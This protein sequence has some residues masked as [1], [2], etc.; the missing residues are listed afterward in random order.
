MYIKKRDR[1]VIEEVNNICLRNHLPNDFNNWLDLYPFKNKMYMFFKIIKQ[2]NKSKFLGSCQNC[3]SIEIKLDSVKTGKYIKCPCCKKQVRLKNEKFLKNFYDRDYVYYITPINKDN[4]ILRQFN[5]TR[6]N[7]YLDYKYSIYEMERTVFYKDKQGYFNESYSLRIYDGNWIPGIYRCMYYTLPS[8]CYI[9]YKNLDYFKDSAYKFIN[10]K[11]LSRKIKFYIG[12][13]F[14]KYRF[15]PQIE[16]LIKTKM[17]NLVIDILKSYTV[18]EQCFSKEH[19]LAKFLGLSR[20]N[21]KF[22]LNNN[23]TLKQL[24]G[25]KFLQVF[26]IKPSVK[27]CDFANELDELSNR[28]SDNKY[29]VDKLGFKKIYNYYPTI[30]K[31]R[32][33]LVDYFDYLRNCKTLKFDIL[34][35]KYCKPYNFKIAHDMAYKRVESLKNAELYSLVRK[36]LDKYRKFN[37]VS[38]KYSVVMPVTA[39]DI[40]LEGKYMHNCVGSY[41][42]RVSK[43]CSII[44][45]IRH[46][47]ELE[48]SFYTLELD[49]KTLKIVQCRGFENEPT[50]EEKQVKSF[51]NKWLREVVNKIA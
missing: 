3:K 40:V 5:I 34:D 2:G 50:S 12:S 28:Y 21:Y 38:E 4:F 13:L 44:C 10:F 51:V 36:E 7:N 45:F 48:K 8:D 46:T 24:N 43:G 41:L 25:L 33:K 16:Y 14:D 39:E 23:I 42:G 26:N 6:V 29:I 31:S 11:L 27:K 22:A 49:P 20:S 30:L 1:E 9:Y 18:Y 15:Y 32:L 35:T 17:F 19:N 47:K 37:Y